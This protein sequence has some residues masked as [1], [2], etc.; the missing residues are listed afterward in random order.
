[1]KTW[2]INYRAEI[3]NRNARDYQFSVTQRFP[4][5]EEAALQAARNHVEPIL[6]RRINLSDIKINWINHTTLVPK[7]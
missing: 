6:H 3:N 1:M 4:P 5:T 7:Y 2:L